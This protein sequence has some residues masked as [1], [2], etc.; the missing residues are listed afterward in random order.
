MRQPLT[1]RHPHTPTAP[2]LQPSHGP[3]ATTDG[4]P[5][6]EVLHRC[7]SGSAENTL[8]WPP[9]SSAQGGSVWNWLT[10]PTHSAS[11][12]SREDPDPNRAATAARAARSRS[13]SPSCQKG[14]RRRGTRR[15]RPDAGG[16][17]ARMREIPTQS[18]FTPT[19]YHT[20]PVYAV[21]SHRRPH[22]VREP[23]A[24][25]CV[26]VCLLAHSIF[27]VLCMAPL[28]TWPLF[29]SL[30]PLGTSRGTSSSSCRRRGTV[31]VARSGA[32]VSCRVVCVCS[33]SCRQHRD[34]VLR[35]VEGVMH[36]YAFFRGDGV[37]GEG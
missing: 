27:T 6:F 8:P 25:V 16:A 3:C 36:G 10:R 26:C 21:I 34:R 18:V 1:T 7:S 29:L 14:Q 32:C 30:A 2:A 33:L 9:A 17:V 11:Y 24:S 19:A 37:R 5:A 23:S 4:S 35:L 12:R 20:C 22:H 15:V 28:Q 13:S 31:Y